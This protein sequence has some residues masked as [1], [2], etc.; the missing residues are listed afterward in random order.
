M[1]IYAQQILVWNL[2]GKVSRL[3]RLDRHSGI[4]LDIATRSQN[5]GMLGHPGVIRIVLLQV[6]SLV[7]PQLRPE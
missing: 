5:R 7:L 2:I 1:K 3:G 6:S 4:C